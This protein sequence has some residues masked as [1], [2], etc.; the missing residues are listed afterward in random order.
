MVADAWGDQTPYSQLVV[1]GSAGGVKPDT[2]KRLFDEAT[3]GQTQISRTHRF[4][5]ALE[6][7][8]KGY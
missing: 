3:L 4:L 8:R 1:I 7:E 6:M 5:A 2:L